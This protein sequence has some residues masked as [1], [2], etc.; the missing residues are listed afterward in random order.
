VEIYRR[1]ALLLDLPAAAVLAILQ[2]IGVIGAL[3]AYAR[4]QER[5]S[6]EQVL[7]PA[8]ETVRRPRSR[9]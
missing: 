3:A 6:V 9:R 4:Y 8:T 7:R 2:M 1:S 5:H